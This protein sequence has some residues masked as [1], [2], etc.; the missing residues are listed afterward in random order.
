M[1][2]SR[3][4][5]LPDWLADPEEYRFVHAL[6]RAKDALRWAI[7]KIRSG[8]FRAYLPVWLT[9]VVRWLDAGA[10]QELA[11]AGSPEEFRAALH[12]GI[13][14][15][16]SAVVPGR[17]GSSLLTSAYIAT[18]RHGEWEEFMPDAVQLQSPD[19]RKEVRTALTQALEVRAAEWVDK[20]PSLKKASGP[21]AQ[22]PVDAGRSGSSAAAGPVSCRLP[23]ASAAASAAP[24]KAAARPQ[25][26]WAI[27]RPRRLLM[28][29][30]KMRT[31][32]GEDSR[33]AFAERCGVSVSGIQRAEKGQK[34]LRATI[35]GAAARLGVNPQV[36]IR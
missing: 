9:Y 28:N 18:G 8:D 16:V 20:F 31:L 32:R 15:M 5:Q 33:E 4:P 36:L 22:A 13:P 19:D 11:T 2:D 1:A 14:R 12:A 26:T 35:A 29:A 3:I 34:W 21:G 17:T 30:K 10:R 6:Q 7:R 27:Q 23:A 25:S 24:G